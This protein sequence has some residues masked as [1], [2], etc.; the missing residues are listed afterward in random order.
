M[1]EFRFGITLGII[2]LSCIVL[3]IFVAIVGLRKSLI[4]LRYLITFQWLLE[5]IIK[6]REGKTPS[7]FL[8]NEFKNFV[9]NDP[10]FVDTVIKQEDL[11][12]HESKKHRKEHTHDPILKPHRISFAVDK[13]K[14]QSSVELE[15]IRQLQSCLE[16]DTHID[17]KE[18]AQISKQGMKLSLQ[19]EKRK[20]QTFLN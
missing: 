12:I 19:A 15:Q 20:E 17:F 11:A 14:N 9:E 13:T 16:R 8:N 18:S 2:V 6:W 5:I 3:A 4:K 10:E 7:K 1:K